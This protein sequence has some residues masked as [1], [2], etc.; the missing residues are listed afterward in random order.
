MPRRQVWTS[1]GNPLKSIEQCIFV[2]TFIDKVI[3][4]SGVICK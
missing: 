2:V 3:L 1:N 4:P